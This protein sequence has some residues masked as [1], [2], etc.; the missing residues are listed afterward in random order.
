MRICKKPCFLFL[1]LLLPLLSQGQKDRKHDSIVH[2]I[3][4]TSNDSLKALHYLD[5][6]DLYQY[7]QQDSALSYYREALNLAKE[8]GYTRL[9]GKCLNYI[10]VVYIYR[11][12]YD[13]TIRYLR[14]S[15]A[16]KEKAGDRG[17]MANGY[18][19]LGVI[20]KNQGNFSKALEY[21]QKAAGIRQEMAGQLKDSTSQG[22]NTEKLGQANNNLGNIHFQFGNYTQAVSFY[23]KGLEHF[24]KI[25][26]HQGISACYNNIGNVF[27]EQQNYFKARQYYRR[28]LELNRRIGNVP[29]IGT[30]LNNLG[31]VHLKQ[32][33]IPRARENFEE[34]LEYR[35]KVNDKRGISGV[36]SNLAMIYM[37]KGDYNRSQDYLHDAL[38]L[39]NEIGDKKGMAEDMISMAKVHLKQEQ[40]P[41]AINI[42][43]Q[44]KELADSLEIPLQQKKSLKILAQAFEK[45]GNYRKALS[46]TRQFEQI[47]DRL[48]NKEKNQMVEAIETRYQLEQKQKEIE[49]QE[50]LLNR[51]QDLIEKHEVEKY[52]LMGGGLVVLI[53]SVLIYIYYRNKRRSYR[54]LA[55]QK[56]EIESQNEELLQQNEQISRQRDELERQRQLTQSKKEELHNKDSELIREGQYA[57]RIQSSLLMS[58]RTLR[59]LFRGHF[60]FFQPRDMVSGDFYWVRQ[61]ND[62]IAFAVVGCTGHG[63]PGAFMSMLGMSFLNEAAAG[64]EHFQA[65]ELLNR[66]RHKVAHAL[67][68]EDPAEDDHDKLE[69]ALCVWDLPGH[70]L[71]FAGSQRPL[72]LYRQGELIEFL[73][74][75]ISIARQT[76]LEES[77]QSRVLDLQ[78]QDM[79]YLFTRG[80]YRQ[81]SQDR[82]QE[83]GLERLRGLLSE[84]HQLPAHQQ[85]EKVVE[86]WENWKGEAPQHAD[87]LLMGMRF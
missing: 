2:L 57:R 51:Q 8:G 22:N 27:E 76:Q 43:R 59:Q 70:R 50:H 25:N 17:G 4:K 61:K 64:M 11:S 72:Y 33:Q 42:A 65:G 24:E 46:F 5:L 18:N 77:F 1:L 63:V 35:R 86:Y 32:N 84:V 26:D 41:R 16:L 73:P 9:A 60:L 67:Q 48:F 10:A 54:L 82:Q 20:H 12:E 69:V 85:K 55:E 49:R 75:D 3:D 47:E 31:E 40:I 66:L 38:K 23:K 87:V 53:L 83:M 44:G 34:S 7:R 19:N 79:I 45:R 21:Y 68:Q 80:L 52:A 6:G 29:N 13:Q 36:Y 14:K 81:K 37:K 62:Q 28:A 58:T 39:D 56:E 78:P 71:Q 15:I 74:D 30:C